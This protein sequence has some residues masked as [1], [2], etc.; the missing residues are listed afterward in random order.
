MDPGVDTVNAR[1]VTARDASPAGAAPPPRPPR[2]PPTRGTTV[3]HHLTPETLFGTVVVGPDGDRIGKVDEVY[4]DNA[5]GRPE[6]VSVKTGLFGSHVSLVPL[7]EASVSGD[8]VTVPFDKSLVKDAPH[9]DPGVELSATDEADLYRYY[10]TAGTTTTTGTTGGD[11]RAAG[12][13]TSG[14]DTDDAMTRSREELHVG[15]EVREAGRAR[16][17]KY[18]TSEAVSRTVT[19]S[20]DELVVTRE[21][22]TDANR[23]AA[24]SGGDLTEEEH[25]IVL[26]EERAVAAKET[27]PVERVRLGT[28]TVTGTETVS[29]E[30]REEHIELDADAGVRVEDRDRA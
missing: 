29:A 26:T 15:T 3:T 2:G 24:L 21:P 14:P 8:T 12:H 6:W 17:R 4:L 16:L 28:R 13:D 23:A 19:V 1:A 18:V 27:V 11:V 7:A 22:I 30:L 25:E 9:H 20:H 10:G 5:T